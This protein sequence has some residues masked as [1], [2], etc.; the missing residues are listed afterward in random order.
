MSSNTKAK[1]PIHLYRSIYRNVK[2]ASSSSS[3]NPLHTHLKQEYLKAKTTTT[4][5]ASDYNT[6]L[7]DLNERKRLYELDASAENVLGGKEMSRRA[8]ARAGL[9]LPKTYS[10]DDTD[11]KE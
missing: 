5:I 7:S 4:E 3:S 6:L 9:Q 2:K 10:D 8:A 1:V 11:D